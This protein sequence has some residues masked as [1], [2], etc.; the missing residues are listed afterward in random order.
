MDAGAV[1]LAKRRPGFGMGRRASLTRDSALSEELDRG[2]TL[3]VLGGL[4]QDPG[5]E[6][7]GRVV[8]GSGCSGS[9]GIKVR[10]RS[11]KSSAF[12]FSSRRWLSSTS[13]DA[14]KTNTG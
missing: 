4:P 14:E 11:R 5:G 13:R 3:S 1:V 12:F 2:G 8:V 10:Y 6:H 9:V 7:G